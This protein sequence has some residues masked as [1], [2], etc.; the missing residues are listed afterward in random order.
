MIYN[1]KKYKLKEIKNTLSI[2]DNQLN[3][4]TALIEFESIDL[5]NLTTNKK[6]HTYETDWYEILKS[7]GIDET[8]VS[9]HYSLTEATYY[10][11]WNYI[12]SKWDCFTY[13]K[14]VCQPLF[15]RQLSFKLKLNIPKKFLPFINVIIIFKTQND[16]LHYEGKTSGIN[17]ARSDYIIQNDNEEYYLLWDVWFEKYDTTMSHGI[18]AK[19]II[20]IYNPFYVDK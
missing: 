10:N 8:A 9:P 14:T 20:K 19:T 3:F 1:E 4:Q 16:V 6:I 2:V 12:E 17:I 11:F 7:S 5:V 15:L 18:Q 13:I